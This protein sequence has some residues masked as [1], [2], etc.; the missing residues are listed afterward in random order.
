MMKNFISASLLSAGLILIGGAPGQTQTV[1]EFF[2]GKTLTLYVGTTAGGTY[3]LY[4]RLVARHISGHIPGQ[5]SIVVQ[6]MPGA[7]S[8][9]LANFLFNNAPRDGTAIGVIN[10]AMPIEQFMQPDGIRYK[11]QEF[12]WIGRATSAVETLLVWHTVPITSIYDTLTRETV[13]GGSGPTSSTVFIP[14][15]LNNLAG[16]KF[17]VVPGY[18]GMPEA[19]L[20]MER[21]EVEGMGVP[22]QS[23]KSNRAD[24]VSQSKIKIIIQLTPKRHPELKDVPTMV[25]LGTTEEGRK[26]LNL[27]ASASEIGRAIM[28]PP[29]IPRDRAT[30]LRRAFDS[31]MTDKA[32]LADAAKQN[33]DLDPMNGED[34]QSLVSELAAFPESLIP[35]ARAARK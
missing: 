21:G 3:D 27:H 23:L 6:N 10:Q 4:G 12:T 31:S 22:L 29:G 18:S 20:A 24:W 14:K 15:L 5:P 2:E 28:A 8:L 32:L 30:A 13:M 1:R 19:G 7:A 9:R 26:I 17:K 16:T 35:A 25:E 11:A 34:L 33:M